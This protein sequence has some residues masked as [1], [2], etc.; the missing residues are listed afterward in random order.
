MPYSQKELEAQLDTIHSGLQNT[1][2]DPE[3][4]SRAATVGYDDAAIQHGWDLYTDARQKHDQQKV[5]YGEQYF[6]SQQ[7]QQLTET[8][9]TT[10]IR[11]VKLGRLAFGKD[12]AALRTLG[13]LGKRRESLHGLMDQGYQFYN[14]ILANN[15]L[16][17]GI[18]KFGVSAEDL[19]AAKDQLDALKNAATKQ[20]KEMA[21]AQEATRI[22]DE[23]VDEIAE[24]YS[25]YTQAMRIACEDAP[26]LLEKLGVTVR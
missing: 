1:M 20:Q 11:H 19:T 26:Q 21:E 5:E 7:E 17:S 9:H 22:R 15:E 4:Q 12:A 16:Q 23:A 24:W 14:N 3:L 8:F 25:T 6:A 2:D 13:L 18:A 10:Y